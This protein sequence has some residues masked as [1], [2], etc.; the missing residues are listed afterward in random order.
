MHQIYRQ[1]IILCLLLISGIQEARGAD[2]VTLLQITKNDSAADSQIFLHF[3]DLPAYRLEASGQRL[4]VIMR[5][6][7]IAPSFMDLPEDQTIVSM[8]RQKTGDET[9]LSFLLR[10][11]PYSLDSSFLL[12]KESSREPAGHSNQ[13][14][15]ILN[16]HWKEATPVQTSITILPNPAKLDKTLYYQK[17]DRDTLSNPPPTRKNPLQEGINPDVSGRGPKNRPA[18]ILKETVGALRA[19]PDRATA[20]RVI[21]SEYAGEWNRFLKEYETGVTIPV[22]LHYSLPPFP[23]LALARPDGMQSV[24]RV[25]FQEI[26]NQGKTQGWQQVA[27][28]LGEYVTEKT[29]EENQEG[30]LLLYGESLV[31]AGAYDKARNI[32]LNLPKELPGSTIDRTAQYLAVYNLAAAGKPYDA[33]YE[34]SFMQQDAGNSPLVPYLALLQAEIALATDNIDK[35]EILLQEKG[36]QYLGQIRRLFDLRRAD[37]LFSS[38]RVDEA[39]TLY[40]ALAAADLPSSGGGLVEPF[41]FNQALSAHDDIL[42]DH[43]S[44]LAKYAAILYQK[45]DYQSALK[46]Y[47]NLTA[48]LY[49]QPEQNLALYAAAMSQYNSGN[50][51]EAMLML[52]DIITKFPDSE[53]FFRARLKINDLFVL[54]ELE[55]KKHQQIGLSGLETEKSFSS[56][57]KDTISNQKENTD[58]PSQQSTD[59]SRQND[60]TGFDPALEYADIAANAPLRALREEAAFKEALT[61]YFKTEYEK[62]VELL[63]NFTRTNSSGVLIKEAEALLVEILPVV[64]EDKIENKDYVDALVLAEQNRAILISG[65]VKGDFLAEL[66]LAFASLCFWNKAVRVYLYRMDI[67]KDKKEEETVYLP[68]VQ[69]YYEKNDLA[70][71]EEYSRRYLADFP[72]GEDRAAIMHLQISALYK[73]NRTDKALRLLKQKNLPQSQELHALAGRIFYE[74][75]DYDMAA[76]HL[77]KIMTAGLNDVEPEAVLL[78]AEA[79]FRSGRGVAALPLYRHLENLDAFADQAAYRMAQVYMATDDHGA[80]LK[81]LQVLVEKARSPL[82]RK[83]AIETLAMEKI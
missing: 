52:E 18:I 53:G 22:P 21:T 34:L 20:S 60:F 8:L 50:S 63:Q 10:R 66:G 32:L 27:G 3:S 37:M 61:Y 30:M 51:K 71:V 7:T 5:G 44:S 47:I 41:A 70:Q 13:T 73:N 1:I 80:G 48:G 45:G 54:S 65:K 76:E 64:V 55:N 11:P 17:D 78:R 39:F 24:R 67:A 57:D 28:R 56:L 72:D 14:R 36:K 59:K 82:W 35:A 15:L 77:A 79:L 16:I 69:A 75:G 42:A 4:D 29:T 26:I 25:N 12:P 2:T 68:L 23:V 83:M 19:N 74:V 81:L 58:T 31:R 9:T 46:Q 62:S 33:A 40:K 6:V 43:P 38:G 49:D